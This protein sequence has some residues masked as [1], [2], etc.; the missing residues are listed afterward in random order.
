MIQYCQNLRKKDF[1]V[2]TEALSRK[3]LG[4][5]EYLNDIGTR[6]LMGS[7][8]LFFESKVEIPRIRVGKRQTI[9]TLID[10][11]ALLLAAFLRDERET[12]MPRIAVSLVSQ[13]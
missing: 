8:N 9:E 3:K 13:L 2:K 10:E 5:R 6:D 12:W 7:L 11:E 1:T 4:K